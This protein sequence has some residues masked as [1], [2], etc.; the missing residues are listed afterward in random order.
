MLNI[1]VPQNP[2]NVFSVHELN[3]ESSFAINHSI[4]VST[5]PSK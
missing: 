1:G 4:P 2:D 3:S 5:T